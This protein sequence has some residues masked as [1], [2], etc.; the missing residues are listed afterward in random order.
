LRL[1][2]VC[3]HFDSNWKV[4]MKVQFKFVNIFSLFQVSNEDMID[5]A[6]IFMYVAE[7]IFSR[8]TSYISDYNSNLLVVFSAETNS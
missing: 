3:S 2:P 8:S 1:Q 6:L 5:C 4:R 7:L